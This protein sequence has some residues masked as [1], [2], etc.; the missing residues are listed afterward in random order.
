ML[1]VGVGAILVI[2]DDVWALNLLGWERIYIPVG[3]SGAFVFIL[4][5]LSL[6]LLGMTFLSFDG[7]FAAKKMP[8]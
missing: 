5:G 6:V 3:D 8:H 2:L 1:S 4:L 7:K